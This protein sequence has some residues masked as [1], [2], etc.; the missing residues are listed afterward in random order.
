[1]KKEF[2]ILAPQMA[3]IHFRLLAPAL[4]RAGYKVRL[5]EHASRDSMTGLSH[6]HND[7][8]YPAI[9]VIGQL[10][11]QFANGIA[12]PESTA[13]IIT[14][15]GGMCRATNYAALL[16]KGLGDAGYPQVPSSPPPLRESR[17][18]QASR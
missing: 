5:L 13:V 8:C 11:S 3:P 1:M 18:T 15:T 16:R 12:D 10:I 9:V 7:A 2:T 14:Q 4:R 17:R 6:V